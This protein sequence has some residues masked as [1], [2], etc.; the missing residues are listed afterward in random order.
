VPD[1]RGRLERALAILEAAPPDVL[2][3]NLE[4]VPRLYKQVRPGSDYAHSLRLLRE[5]KVR[6]PG[7]PTKSG[8][9][10]GL[11]ETDDE[12]RAT[13][14]DMR[15][16]GIDMLT[17]GQY[18]QPSVGHLP[19]LRYVHPDAFVQFER[20]AYA[21]GFRHAAVGALVRSSYHADQQAEGVLA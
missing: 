11:G 21:M 8:L 16:H 4:S 10:V 5:F 1:F 14:R 6:V 17:L 3:H 7:V 15:A 2:N 18:L 20:D 9:M 19:V 12:I 13:M